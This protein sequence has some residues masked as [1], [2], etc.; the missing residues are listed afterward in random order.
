TENGA[1]ARTT[2]GSR[3]RPGLGGAR[4]RCPSGR[5]RC[6]E[7]VPGE[8]LLH[9][10]RVV[11][12]ELRF[13]QLW[14]AADLFSVLRIPWSLVR[15]ALPAVRP[16]AGPLRGRALA[17]RLCRA[18][19]RLRGLVLSVVGLR[20]SDISGRLR[21][22]A[23]WWPGGAPAPGGRLCAGPGAGAPL[24]LVNRRARM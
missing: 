11:R 1:P 7:L 14:D 22:R 10:A 6:R 8:Q 17:A 13:C 21:G 16:A 3:D 15:R 2:W 23:R 5:Q 19:V 12:D 18:W 4:G 20:L 9:R 24:R